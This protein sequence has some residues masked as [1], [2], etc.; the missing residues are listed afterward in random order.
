MNTRGRGA[1]GGGDQHQAAVPQPASD[2]QEEGRDNQ[3]KGEEYDEKKKTERRRERRGRTERRKKRRGM[4]ERR[5][6][7]TKHRPECDTYD[8]GENRAGAACQPDR[9]AG[10]EPNR[11]WQGGGGGFAKRASLGQGLAGKPSARDA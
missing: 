2:K 5:R 4:A 8:R 9:V 1:V 6:R 11:E 3:R 10:C 7:K